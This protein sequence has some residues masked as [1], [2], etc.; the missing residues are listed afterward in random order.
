MRYVSVQGERVPAVGLGTWRLVGDDCR[1]LEGLELGYRHIDTAQGYGNESQVGEA[2]RSALVAREELFITTKIDNHNHEPKR[3]RSSTEE[4]LRALGSEYVDL[5]LI[6]WP[7]DRQQ[8]PFTLEAMQRLR[9]DG[10]VRFIGVSN[11]PPALL[12]EA[13]RH[14]PVFCDQ[15]EFHPF[16]A[17]PGVMEVAREHDLLV[18]AYSPL[19]RGK[20]PQDTTMR[21]IAERKGKAPGQVALRWLIDQERVA[22]IPKASSREHLQAN[23]DLF[24]FELSDEE[25]ER[26]DALDRAER[27]I[28]PPF[29]PDWDR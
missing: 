6:H 8:L 27:I 13:L 16:L 7:G 18:T 25:R 26:I 10:K 23:L 14:A 19:A 28:N 9:D 24:D 15:V 17:Q 20:V 5:L 29:A 11:F 1:V 3:V 2:M 4:S 12:R 21:Q 22:V